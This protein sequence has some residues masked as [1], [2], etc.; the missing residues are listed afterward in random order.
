M[1]NKWRKCVKVQQKTLLVNFD[2]VLTVHRSIILV[3]NQ[4]NGQ[5]FVL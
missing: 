4:L 5:N 1:C 3:I 2:I